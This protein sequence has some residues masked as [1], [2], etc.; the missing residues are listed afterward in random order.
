V[1][2]QPSLFQPTQTR[3][4]LASDIWRACDILRRD[5]NCGGVMEYVEHLA[6]LL[7][8]LQERTFYGQEKKAVPAPL[9]TLNLV[10]HGVTAPHVR[11]ANTLSRREL[12]S[13]A[14]RQVQ[15]TVLA[16]TLHSAVSRLCRRVGVQP[17]RHHPVL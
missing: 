4:S 10:L 14:S 3:A 5:N 8:L 13:G 6:W 7:F 17:A 9:G 15:R 1:T 2:R 12:G 16:R 11:R